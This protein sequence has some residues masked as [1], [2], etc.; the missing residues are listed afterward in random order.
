MCSTKYVD[1]EG[2]EKKIPKKMWKKNSFVIYVGERI[3]VE[4]DGVRVTK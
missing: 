1:D 4:G 2:K 3:S